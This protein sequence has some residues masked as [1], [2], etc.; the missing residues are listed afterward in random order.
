VRLSAVTLSVALPAA[1][2]ARLAGDLPRGAVVWGPLPLM[3]FRVCPAMPAGGCTGCGGAP[4]LTDRRGVRW[5][6]LCAEKQYSRLLNPVPLDL[7]GRDLPGID[8]RLCY[9][10]AESAADCAGVVDRFLR[11][12]RPTGPHTTGMAFSRLL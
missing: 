6:V 7:S 8:Y 11:G 4:Q 5:T 1:D 2:A 10:T 3:R 9:F 12:G